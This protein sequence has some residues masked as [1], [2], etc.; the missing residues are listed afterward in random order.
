MLVFLVFSFHK[1]L[2]EVEYE[3]KICKYT[4]LH[5]VFFF[6]LLFH[7]ELVGKATDY[8]RGQ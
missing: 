3:A 1:S 6:F 7:F 2:L 8:I 4:E 5:Y